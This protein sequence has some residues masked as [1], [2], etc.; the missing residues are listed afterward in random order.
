MIAK[1]EGVDVDVGKRTSTREQGADDSTTVEP[2]HGA[3]RW[4]HG[5][6]ARLNTVAWSFD[7]CR[8]SWQVRENESRPGG[9]GYVNLCR[10]NGDCLFFLVLFPLFPFSPFPLLET[11]KNKESYFVLF[12]PSPT[13]FIHL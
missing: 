12:L 10:A 7:P 6:N 11:V 5:D 3:T 4:I 13:S 9:C 2:V 8:G 1:W